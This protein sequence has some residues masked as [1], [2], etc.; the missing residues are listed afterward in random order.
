MKNDSCSQAGL[1]HGI[2]FITFFV[3]IPV[4]WTFAWKETQSERSLPLSIM[5][6]GVNVPQGCEKVIVF[7]ERFKVD[8]EKKH[9]LLPSAY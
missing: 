9:H 6:S 4:M 7:Q 2:L 3:F 5:D 8:R 1:K